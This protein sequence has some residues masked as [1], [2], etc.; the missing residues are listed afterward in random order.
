MNKTFSILSR[1]NNIYALIMFVMIALH[2]YLYFLLF[3]L[4]AHVKN[5][6]FPI[7]GNRKFSLSLSMK[8][9]SCFSSS[10]VCNVHYLP[11]KK[12]PVHV[13]FPSQALVWWERNNSAVVFVHLK[14]FAK[15]YLSFCGPFSFTFFYFRSSVFY[16]IVEFKNGQI[17]I[18]NIL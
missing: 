11:L 10:Y 5:N 6:W 2:S 15:W 7:K 14:M 9:F 1:I 4:C 18:F 17:V 12:N 3:L 8:Y 13:V 16:A